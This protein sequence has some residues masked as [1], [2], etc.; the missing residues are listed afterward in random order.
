MPVVFS[1]KSYSCGPLGRVRRLLD[2]VPGIP[3]GVNWTNVN[4]PEAVALGTTLWDIETSP[5]D[6]NHVFAVGD[7]GNGIGPIP[8]FYGVAVSTNGGTNWLIPTG[9]YSNAPIANLGDAHP[10]QWNE[11]VVVGPQ[12]YGFTGESYLIGSAI[13]P[14]H[15]LAAIAK[16]TDGGA[17]Y[18]LIGLNPG[19]GDW[20]LLLPLAQQGNTGIINNDG[21]S[22]H[23]DGQVGVVGLSDYIIKSINGGTSWLIMNDGA[24]LTDAAANPLNTGPLTGITIKADQ[25]MVT[26]VCLTKVVTTCQQAS[27]LAGEAIN[28]WFDSSASL[29]PTGFVSPIGW[30]ISPVAAPYD[31]NLYITGDYDLNLIANG[32]GGCTG[33]ANPGTYYTGGG[34]SRRA[35]HRFTFTGQAALAG[36]N[37]ALY[38]QNNEVWFTNNINGLSTQLFDQP[39]QGLDYIPNAIWN[40]YEETQVSTCYTLQNCETL[41]I[42]TTSTNLLG[43]MGQI[44]TLTDPQFP[45]CWTVIGEVACDGSEVA[46]NVNLTFRTCVDCLPHPCYYL[47][48]CNNPLI[49]YFTSTDLSLYFT[50]NKIVKVAEYSGCFRV[51]QAADCGPVV[52]PTVTVTNSYDDCPA[53]YAPCYRLE[54]CLGTASDIITNTD[55]SL[56]VGNVIQIANSPVCWQVFD[57][58]DD[59]T[60]AVLV[61]VT[62]NFIDCTACLPVCYLLTDCVDPLNTIIVSNAIPSL[63]GQVI[64]IGGYTECWQVSIAPTCV[65]SILV[66]VTNVYGTCIECLP[67]PPPPIPT[68]VDLNPRRVKP[69]YYTP[70]C[71]PAYTE[72]VNCNFADQVYMQMLVPR[73]GISIC[74]EEDVN[75]WDIKKQL[76]EFAA[77][78]DPS[79]CKCTIQVCCPPTCVHAMIQ[80]FNPQPAC[81]APS[82]ATGTITQP[83]PLCTATCWQVDSSS[84]GPCDVDYVDCAGVPRVTTVSG[85]MY[86][87]SIT[88]PVPT[89]IGVIVS[90]TPFNCALGTCGP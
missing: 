72:K 53:C 57:N 40:W 69:G 49:T 65:G 35:A 50:Q 29:P 38:N 44:V 24:A 7:C 23:F 85:I 48:D 27:P 67:P 66:S 58:F 15:G 16:S 68:P 61:T 77:I 21:W 1:S 62:G 54:D 37:A 45:G 34:A 8:P 43:L 9:N 63:V 89:C 47:E 87:C 79:L 6:G 18:N 80:Q 13:V 36:Q 17:S 64:K 46:V 22:I 41:A 75:K 74:C 31:N 30:H 86:L 12:V 56:Q 78:Y 26:A 90:S 81:I 10:F 73:Y 55:L 20:N 82:N 14:T 33:W 3:A 60:G 71:N 39:S 25:T 42:I 19:V 4:V 83:P 76:L 5:N 11:I 88:V 52:P 32:G 2:L 51:R 70:G 28:T 84:V 59:C